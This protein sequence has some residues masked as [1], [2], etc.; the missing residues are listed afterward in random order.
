M[1]HLKSETWVRLAGSVG[2]LVIA[3][4]TALQYAAGHYGSVAEI[5]WPALALVSA[6]ALTL[7]TPAT[8]IERHE[9]HRHVLDLEKRFEA[10]LRQSENALARAEKGLSNEEERVEP[11]STE[12]D[13]ASRPYAK[14]SRGSSSGAKITKTGRT[15]GHVSK[16]VSSIARDNSSGRLVS[17]KAA[18]GKSGRVGDRTSSAETPG[19]GKKPAKGRSRTRRTS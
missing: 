4:V 14:R 8:L 2:I 9:Q 12:E 7:F 6:I 15:R 5:V 13:I 3:G 11:R 1:Q 10:G 18:D 16:S 19:P 17:V